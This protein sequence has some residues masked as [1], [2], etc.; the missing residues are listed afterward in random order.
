MPRTRQRIRK[1]VPAHRGRRKLQQD[2]QVVVRRAGALARAAPYVGALARGVYNAYRI[3]QAMAQRNR[4]VRYRNER[5]RTEN[6]QKQTSSSLVR[7][8]G[9]F[10]STISKKV[11]LPGSVANRIPRR[12]LKLGFN[13]RV[14]RWQRV[15][16]M[17]SAA[18]GACPGALLLP[19]GTFSTDN[20]A[21]P[22]A[23]FLLNNSI[24]Q[25]GITTGPMNEC[26]FSNTG[27]LTLNNVLSQDSA[28][29]TTTAKWQLEYT[30]PNNGVVPNND[31]EVRY[32]MQAWYDIKLL[33]YGCQSQPTV[34]DIM[35]VSFNDTF[36][37]PLEVPSNNQEADDRHAMW[38]GLVHKYMSN[39]ILT[40][41]L[42]RNKYKVHARTT[43]T[44]QPTL[45]I[46][47]DGTPASKQVRMFVRDGSIY[48]YCYH[49]DGFSGAGADDRLSTANFTTT[50]SPNNYGDNPHPKARKWLIIRA[51][52]TTR[53]AI[54]TETSSNTPSYDIVV[55]K[56]EYLQAR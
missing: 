54:G 42:V 5:K 35:V 13:Y 18:A 10:G 34:Y 22:M 50:T 2:G 48:D 36:N 41:K 45:S 32:I 52:N 23:V 11:N 8:G 40:T 49:S 39:P 53:V 1:K 38:Q 44:I 31:S 21:V 46:E 3:N 56:G 4:N 43:F 51:M 6:A 30:S 17:N 27:Q 15:N 33:C 12:Q 26:R 20:T 28:G 47:N 16:V 37:D 9:E 29:A 19:H 55:R 14:L 25:F 7:H 24:N